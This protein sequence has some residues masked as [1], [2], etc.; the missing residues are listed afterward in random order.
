MLIVKEREFQGI[1]TSLQTGKVA[2]Q[3][4][5]SVLAKAGETVVLATVVSQKEMREGA[6]FIP[7]MVEYRE[8]FYASGKIPGGFIKREGRP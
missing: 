8:K 2:K 1:K 6:D 5:G 3:A 7:L 4:H